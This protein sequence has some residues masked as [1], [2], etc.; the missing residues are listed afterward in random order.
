V[1]QVSKAS[2]QELAELHGALARGLKD[3]ITDGAE[4]MTKEGVAKVTAPAAYFGAAVALLKNNNIT[5]DPATDAGLQALTA[6]LQKKRT[7]RK[8]SMNTGFTE[9]AEEFANKLDG[10]GHFS[11]LLN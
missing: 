4:V 9:A 1:A 5:A 2:E 11:D 6:A 10:S 8:A 3:I 7:D